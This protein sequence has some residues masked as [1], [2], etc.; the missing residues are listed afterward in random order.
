MT[1]GM[2]GEK[3]NQDR[4]RNDGYNAPYRADQRDLQSHEK[5]QPRAVVYHSQIITVVN[6]KKR[7]DGR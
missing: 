5:S 2:S 4:L 6:V 3:A 1:S 7:T